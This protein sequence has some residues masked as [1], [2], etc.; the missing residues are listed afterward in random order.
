MTFVALMGLVAESL[1][2]GNKEYV[3]I[4]H[5]K[6]PGT[7]IRRAIGAIKEMFFTPVEPLCYRCRGLAGIVAGLLCAP[8]TTAYWE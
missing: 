6:N 7:V 4:C 5:R 1:V 3:V 8:P 2:G